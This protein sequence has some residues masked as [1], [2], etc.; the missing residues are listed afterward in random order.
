MI[1]AA[2]RPV[3][4][5]EPAV[6]GPVRRLQVTTLGTGAVSALAAAGVLALQSD[7]GYVRAVLQARSWGAVEV[8]DT[9]VAA[10]LTPA[11]GV[12]AAVAGI[13]ALTALLVWGMQR[14]WRPSR[15]VGTAAA[16]VGM[17]SAAFWNVDGGRMVAAG[18]GGV[19]TL[20][21]VF[22]MLVLC[23]VWLLVAHRH[24]TRDAFD[25]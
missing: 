10:F 1:P 3:G 18:A 6:R 24:S 4:L 23:A 22:A 5:D 8:T 2:E 12:P 13:L 20:L 11:G 7:P 14:L 9:D 19:L 15:W 25:G 17:L 16:G 21:A